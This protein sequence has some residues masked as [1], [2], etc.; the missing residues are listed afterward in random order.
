MRSSTVFASILAF[1]ASALAQAT[2]PGYAVVSAPG[3]GETVPAGKTYTVKWSAGKFSGPATISLLGGKTANTLEILEPLASGI[4]VTQESFSWK[5]DCSL[6]ED[7]TY[8]LKI[9]DDATN[10]ATFQYSF[11]FEIKGPSCDSTT[12]AT[13]SAISSATTSAST[14]VS[15]ST[16]GYPTISISASTSDYST[17]STAILTSISAYPTTKVANSTT[18]AVET[19]TPS[20]SAVKTSTKTSSKATTTASTTATTFA[21]V[22]TPVVVVTETS[23]AVG[24]ASSTPA[25]STTASTPVPTAGAARV[26][27]GVAFG[28]IV[29]ALAL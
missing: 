19:S 1:A 20:S 13:T 12:S 23:A 22:S 11:P 16:S 10:G 27:A 18:S 29:A 2:T 3:D 17:T 4:E 8:G 25:T 9:A 6:G 15:V 5:V 21:T 24:S 26:G 28:V 14:S 7:Q